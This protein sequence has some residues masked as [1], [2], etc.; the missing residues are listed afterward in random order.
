MS[1]QAQSKTPV[2]AQSAKSAVAASSAVGNAPAQV[3]GAA[4]AASGEGL[5]WSQELGACWNRFWFTATDPVSLGWIR[6]LTGLVALYL[7]LTLSFD[8]NRFF[9]PDGYLPLRTS[10]DW[11]EWFIDT[12]GEPMLKYSYLSY[13]Q[14]PAQLAAAHWVGIGIVL[15][16][17]A[18]VMTHVTS[19][20]S[21]VV[22][23]TYFHRAPMITAQVEPIIAMLMFYLCLGPAGAAVSVDAW[24]QERK[25]RAD[26]KLKPEEALAV[27]PRWSATVVLRLIQIHLCAFYLMGFI[28]KISGGAVGNVWLR[29]EA[30]WWVITEPDMPLVDFTWIGRFPVLIDV[31][32]FAVLLFEFSFPLLVWNRLL[33]PVMLAISVPMW[34]SLGLASGLMTYALAM[35]IGGLAFADPQWLRACTRYCLAKRTKSVRVAT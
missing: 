12:G 32:T 4:Y 26:L 23:L 31:W 3:R 14:T 13:L 25:R 1:A 9:G 21:L 28:A 19:V 22:M 33:R 34:I 5:S 17:T 6:L 7:L 27:Q 16:F 30:M 2:R 20:L 8:L 24:L 15:L 11:Y 10:V 18:G 29:G 35:L